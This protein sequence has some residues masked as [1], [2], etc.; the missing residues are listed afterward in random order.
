MASKRKAAADVEAPGKKP[1]TSGKAEHFIGGKPTAPSSG[2][3]MV[4]TNP[5]TG[6]ESC[7]VAVGTVADVDAAVQAAKAAGPAW[8]ALTVGSRAKI[9]YNFRQLLIDHKE[10]LADLVVEE[11]GKNRGEAYGSIAKGNET[12]AWAASLPAIAQGK[13]LE[14]SRGV[15]CHEIREPLGVVA[16]IVPFNFPIMV[17]MW[18]LPIA[19]T[20]GNCM[21]LKPSEKVPKTM[22]RVM[23]LLQEAGVPD[24]V[25][26]L[27]NGCA[28][29]VNAI[30]DHPDISAVSFVGSSRVAELVSKRCR[31]NNK[32]CM[33]MGGAKNHLVALQDCDVA[34]CSHDI[35]NSFVG[36]TGQR[37]MAASVLVLV[38]DNQP[39]LDAIVAKAA[40]MKKGQGA[41]EVGPVIDQA[42]QDR[43]LRYINEAETRDGATVLLD[44]R[45]WAEEKEGWWVGPTILQ[46]KSTKDAACCEEIFGPVLSIVQVDTREAAIEMENSSP[47][48]NAACIYTSSGAHAQWFSKRFSVG[49]V[50]VNIGVPVPREPFSFGGSNAS[51]FGDFDVTGDGAMEFFTKRKKVST[52]WNV[53]EKQD[54]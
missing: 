36:C 21:I 15:T 1:K 10:E 40:A 45:S 3:Y 41:G 20:T 33:A 48:G 18:T 4:S 51:K 11:H 35:V 32:R 52:K 28:E 49:M 47:Y 12:V 25:V 34:M 9:M 24:G 50:G 54:W 31:N 16:S 38:G 46:H 13:F 6:A 44:G 43:I 2:K 53:P 19:I 5:A 42:A 7:Q 8:R 14:V 17:P 39:L 22:F 27:V 30:C 23:E 26:N 37:C 29:V